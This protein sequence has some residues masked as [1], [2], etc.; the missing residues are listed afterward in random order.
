MFG[1]E[2][3]PSSSFFRDAFGFFL[4]ILGEFVKLGISSPENSRI[5]GFI[6]NRVLSFGF[7]K[8][9]RFRIPTCGAASPTPT[10]SRVESSVFFISEISF[11][12]FLSNFVTGADFESKPGLGVTTILYI[13]KLITYI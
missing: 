10:G 13:M 11:L 5:S 7:A 12:S 6:K 4:S 1:I 8:K 3:H 9:K 2:R